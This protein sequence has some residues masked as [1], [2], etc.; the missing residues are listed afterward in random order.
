MGIINVK[1][2]SHYV[3]FPLLLW[4]FLL[5]FRDNRL[6]SAKRTWSETSLVHQL[7]CD[8]DMRL[9]IHV[10]RSVN[11]S[12]VRCIIR[13]RCITSLLCLLSMSLWMGWRQSSSTNCVELEQML[14]HCA[15]FFLLPHY[16]F[17]FSVFL[18]L[19]FFLLLAVCVWHTAFSPIGPW[20]EYVLVL[21]SSLQ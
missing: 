17:S 15:A 18:C 9:S 2:V 20:S 4:C 6:H 14:R 13:C 3:T 16:P 11:Y 5:W 10:F 1:Q 12:S 19:V 21:L 8:L 7:I